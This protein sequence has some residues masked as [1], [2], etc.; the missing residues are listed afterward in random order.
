MQPDAKS[1]S[2]LTLQELLN[3]ASVQNAEL[4]TALESVTSK[5]KH[6]SMKLDAALQAAAVKEMPPSENSLVHLE[7]WEPPAIVDLDLKVSAPWDSDT[8]T[9]FDD[10]YMLPSRADAN[11]P[12]IQEWVEAKVL[13]LRESLQ[14]PIPSPGTPNADSSVE[15]LQESPVTVKRQ[16]PSTPLAQPAISS[17]VVITSSLRTP[18]R[19]RPYQTSTPPTKPSRSAQG[20]K[21]VEHIEDISADDSLLTPTGPRG[22]SLLSAMNSGSRRAFSP[23]NLIADI[24]LPEFSD[25]SST[26]NGM[27]SFREF[28]DF[29]KVLQEDGEDDDFPYEGHSVT[30][31][32]ILLRV[33]NGG[34]SFDLI[35]IKL[36]TPFYSC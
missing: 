6:I 32:D 18:R 22:V 35:G 5:G 10:L 26:E 1:P 8:M 27:I 12:Q 15:S 21:Q 23:E 2:S 20:Q 11:N 4:T 14:P 28:G 16:Q 33:G 30:L 25:E 34:D 17:G 13:D 9:F 29:N 19:P 7:L 31:R 36:L 24:S 3:N